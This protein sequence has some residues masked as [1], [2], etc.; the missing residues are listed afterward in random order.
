[1]IAKIAAAVDVASCQVGGGCDRAT[2]RTALFDAGVVPVR[3]RT[4]ALETPSLVRRTGGPITVS[5]WASTS[6]P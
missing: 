5:R 1:M 6:A 2:P 3:D 4:A